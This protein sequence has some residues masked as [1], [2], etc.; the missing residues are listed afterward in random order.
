MVF[1]VVQ[2]GEELVEEAL[3]ALFGELPVEAEHAAPEQGAEIVHVFVRGHPVFLEARVSSLCSLTCLLSDVCLVEGIEQKL[4]RSMNVPKSYTVVIRAY[5]GCQATDAM[6]IGNAFHNVEMQ[7]PFIVRREFLAVAGFDKV[8]DYIVI[9]EGF[10]EAKGGLPVLAFV[11]NAD[12]MVGCGVS[13]CTAGAG[14]LGDAGQGFDCDFWT[15]F[16]LHDF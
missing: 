2:Q 7:F 6:R 10:G 15:R 12:G 16:L 13:S 9:L 11:E 5:D 1:G 4:A 14:G 8:H 3:L